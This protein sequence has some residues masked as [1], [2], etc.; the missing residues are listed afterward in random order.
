MNGANPM[1]VVLRDKNTKYYFTNLLIVTNLESQV[2]LLV[3]KALI[4]CFHGKMVKN[5]A[6]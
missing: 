3:S 5:K 6:R 1:N 4:H 2:K